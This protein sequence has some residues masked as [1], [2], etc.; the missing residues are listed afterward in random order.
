MFI[1]T[2]SVKS[3]KKEHGKHSVSTTEMV[4]EHGI[5]HKPASF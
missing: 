2:F 1:A 3:H 4:K 5:H